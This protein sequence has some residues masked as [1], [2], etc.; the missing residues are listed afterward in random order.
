MQ[1]Y[2]WRENTLKGNT[3]KRIKTLKEIFSDRK[4]LHE[5]ENTLQRYTEGKIHRKRK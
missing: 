1:K 3:L 2:S 4:M 5:R